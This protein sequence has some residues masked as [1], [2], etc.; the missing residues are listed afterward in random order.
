MVAPAVLVG[1]NALTYTVTDLLTA[2]R[3]PITRRAAAR[4]AAPRPVLLIAAGDRPDEGHAARHI[5]RGNAGVQVWK[6][7]DTGHTRALF[8]H[9][10][11]WRQRVLG[12]LAAALPA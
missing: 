6:V 7:P 3:P 12:F 8:T 10:D 11:E 1:I 2:A 5:Q 9:P 4:A